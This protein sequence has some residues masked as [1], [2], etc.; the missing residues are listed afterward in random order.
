MK[1]INASKR[2]DSVPV[3]RVPDD[4]QDLDAVD[5]P[6]SFRVRD[7]S[8]PHRVAMHRHRRAQLLFASRGVMQVTIPDG[9]W[10]VPPQRAVWVPSGVDH[11]VNSS[12][13]I[14]LRNMYFVQEICDGLPTSCCV[15][16]VPPLLRELILHAVQL[17]PLYDEEGPDGRLMQVILDQIRALPVAPL[18]LPL[19]EEPRVRAITDALQTDP[20]DSRSLEEWGH[21]VGA[22]AR[23]LARLFLN[24]TGYT[25]GQWRQQA[26]L[27]SA[28]E[29]L[30]QGQP[31]SVIANELGYENQSAFIAMFRKAL[32]KTPRRF[33]E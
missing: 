20:S 30:A 8:G 32:G 6:V 2:T 29:G 17:P 15:V 22:S 33:F 25:F 26:R 14:S 4:S 21:Q 24:E 31:V 27:L 10:V 3:I 23:T 11:E 7:L 28:L 1:T 18:H 19:S 5:R 9:I 16:T 13:A 12:G